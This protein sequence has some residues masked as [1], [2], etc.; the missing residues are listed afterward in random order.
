[1]FTQARFRCRAFT[2][3]ELLVVL[4]I[5]GVLVALLL[6]A[7][8]AAHEMAN[9]LRC[10]SN[11]RQLGTAVHTFH[12]INHTMPPY[13]GIYPA[14]PAGPTTAAVAR[15]TGSAMYGGWFAHLLPYVEQQNLQ[16][17]MNQEIKAA[18][19]NSFQQGA[20][21]SPAMPG[22]GGTSTGVSTTIIRNGY[23]YTYLRTVQT[24][25]TPPSAAVYAPGAYHGIWMDGAYNATFRILQCPSDLSMGPN[26]SGGQVYLQSSAQN[27][28]NWGSTNYEPNWNA[29]GD[30][31][32]NKGWWTP[33]Q[34][35]TAITDGLSQTIL[36][37]E[38]YAWCDSLAHCPLSAEP[39][40]VWP[41][42]ELQPADPVDRSADWERADGALQSE[43][44]AQSDDVPGSTAALCGGPVSPRPN[45]LRQL[46]RPD[47]ARRHERG[48]GRR[49]RP[50]HPSEHF[51]HDLDPALASPRRRDTGDGLVMRQGLRGARPPGGTFP[52]QETLPDSA[53]RPHRQTARDLL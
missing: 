49:Q 35:F 19:Y 7:L 27:R 33:P 48:H 51:R 41:V 28:S 1:M 25:E 42:H 10:Q 23:K 44:L 50:G 40:D 20:L 15:P 22:S 6:S 47:G 37:G 26:A 53:T 13:F 17:Q 9:Q 3:L 46:G 43:R 11:L 29:W 21:I 39:A 31:D 4:A 45:V 52:A 5:L 12:D 8:Q 34:R 32:P 14:C 38:A 36:F 2:L 18:Q 16:D 24:W 30:G